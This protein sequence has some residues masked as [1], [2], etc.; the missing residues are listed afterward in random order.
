M[1]PI[2]QLFVMHRDQPEATQWDMSR[3]TMEAIMAT[4]PTVEDR[5]KRWSPELLG[6]PVFF[7]TLPFGLVKLRATYPGKPIEQMI[8]WG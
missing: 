5:T 4:V 6:L 7:S 1:T 3:E 8:E 2:E